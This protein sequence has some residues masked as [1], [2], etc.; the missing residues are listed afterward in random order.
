[1]QRTLNKARAVNRIRKG[2]CKYRTDK[3]NKIKRELEEKR[4]ELYTPKN[5]FLKP[6]NQIR[7][8]Q[9]QMDLNQ[10][11]LDLETKKQTAEEERKNS[12]NKLKLKF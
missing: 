7:S 1:M 6:N 2:A 12:C 11:I 8:W 9:K 5:P 3:L 4:E 10:I